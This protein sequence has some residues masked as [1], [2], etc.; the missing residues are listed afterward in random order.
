MTR[1]ITGT[2]LKN[3]G[4]AWANGKMVFTLKE[5]IKTSD[6][7]FPKGSTTLTLD[8]NGAFTVHLGVPDSGTVP[9]TIITPDRVKHNVT[10]GDGAATDLQS[11]L[12]METPATAPNY[13]Q[14][15][16]DEHVG[17][18]DP[19][20]QYAKKYMAQSD[21]LGW[22][23]GNG[24]AA[25]DLYSNSNALQLNT[26]L[27]IQV[28]E[29][30]TTPACFGVRGRS[31]YDD[32]AFASE[33][34]GHDF[35]EFRQFVSGTHAWGPG[36]G[37]VDLYL[38]RDGASG[39]MIIG[40]VGDDYKDLWIHTH[41]YGVVLETSAGP[42]FLKA[43]DGV[44]IAGW[45]YLKIFQEQDLNIFLCSFMTSYI[46]T[47][48]LVGTTTDGMTAGGS[49]AVAKD[50]AHRGTKAGFFNTTPITKPTGVAVTAAGIHAALVSLGLIAA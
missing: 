46:L 42:L 25:I 14:I 47:N 1:T 12:A 49:F 45:G 7:V 36:S 22:A 34:D 44:Q 5:T 29:N 3:D 9:Y 6:D 38:Y 8:N 13:P 26:E 27:R 31:G 20:A 17:Q 2:V 10:I 33:S 30:A 24:N 32:I 50:L 16:M 18:D 23:A 21:H 11:I 28:P 48:F 15:A 43:A 19:H 39:K 37:D 4:T 41:D 35:N 40:N